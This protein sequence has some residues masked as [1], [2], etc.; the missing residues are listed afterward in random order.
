MTPIEYFESDKF[1]FHSKPVVPKFDS[2]FED[3]QILA[4]AQNKWIPLHASKLS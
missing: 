4:L 1:S 3:S 2:Y